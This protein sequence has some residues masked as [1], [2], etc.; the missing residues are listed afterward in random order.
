M[1][2]GQPMPQGQWGQQQY[3][4]YPPEDIENG[5]MMAVLGYLISP[6]WIVPL[7]QRDNAFSLFHA[8]QAL[9]YTVFMTI[10][11]SVIG[12][13]STITC[14]FGA[15]LA[16]AIFPFMYPWIM[17][18]VYSAQGEYKPMPWIGHFADQYLGS[19]TADKRPMSPPG[20][21]QN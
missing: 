3:N 4:P 12:I 18:I 11:G 10:L 14:G 5:K 19:M 20:Y 9:V 7:V 1:Q 8:K 15:I 2:Q 16:V 17:G 6:I 13:L 21:P